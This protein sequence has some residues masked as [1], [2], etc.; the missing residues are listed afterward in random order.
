MK[1]TA[2]YDRHIELGAKIVS[3][4]GYEL[5][6]SYPEGIIREH[7]AVRKK[8]GIFDI[9][10]MGEFIISGSDA[11]D[12]LQKLTTNDVSKMEVGDAQYSAM[13]YADGGIVDDFIVYRREDEYLMV[14]N[15]A[16][17]EK[18]YQWLETNKFGDVNLQDCSSDY[19]LIALQGPQSREILFK[20]N[21]SVHDLKFYKSIEATILGH[22]VILSRTGYT[23]ELGFE[24]YGGDDA[25]RDIWDLILVD[26]QVQP[27]GLAAR[28]TLRM[29]M[30]YCLYGNDIDKD[31]N[32]IE[33]GLN[34]IIAFDKGDFIGSDALA[35]VKENK[36][37]RC[38][39]CFILEERGIPRKGY[40]IYVDGEI[41]GSVTSGTQSPSLERGIGLGYV[42]IGFHK[43]GQDIFVLIRNK[44]IR[45]KIIKPP[46]INN[47]SIMS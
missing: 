8:V 21:K 34:W 16:N 23:G 2:L 9:S 13:C 44:P 4:S 11:L 31:T 25:V 7:Q 15:A 26:K 41:V 42:K 17:K 37:T 32:P 35:K 38:L 28:D 30:K 10:H 36:L 1:K 27:V 12:F 24:I 6:I 45:G 47:T 33:A 46:F 40:D 14:V 3:F 5:P 19:S 22:T 43:S 18:D 29:E 39:V 20:L